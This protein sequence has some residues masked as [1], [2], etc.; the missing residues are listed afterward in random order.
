MT[1]IGTAVGLVFGGVSGGV[2]GVIAYGFIG[3]LSPP[4][5]YYLPPKLILVRVILGMG[6]ATAGTMTSFYVVMAVIATIRGIPFDRA[7]GDGLGFIMFGAPAVMICGQIVGSISG[8]KRQ[9]ELHR[10]A[11]S[12][13]NDGV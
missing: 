2:V 12:L 10:A 5:R 6:L 9:K 4:G 7:V 3:F 11:S 8:Y 1:N 13:P